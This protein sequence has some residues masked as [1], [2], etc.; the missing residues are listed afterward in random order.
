[1]FPFI[2]LTLLA[3]ADPRPNLTGSVVDDAGKAVS[4]ARVFLATAAP[5]QGIGLL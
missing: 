3:G 5:R 4:G 2:L 1:M